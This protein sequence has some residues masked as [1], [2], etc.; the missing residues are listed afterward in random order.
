MRRKSSA[1]DAK[2][3][4]HKEKGRKAWGRNHQKLVAVRETEEQ[5]FGGDL[6]RVDI[7]ERI[8]N[9]RLKCV[10][11]EESVRVWGLFDK[12]SSLNLGHTRGG[13]GVIVELKYNKVHNSYD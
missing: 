10:G 7:W 2:G 5:L 13:V 8:V 6:F 9:W 1:L 12:W 3:G 4:G 11:E